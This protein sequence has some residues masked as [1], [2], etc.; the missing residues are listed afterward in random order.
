MRAESSSWFGYL[1]GKTNICSIFCGARHY[2]YFKF[3]YSTSANEMY[4][5][6]K[7]DTK[8]VIVCH[9]YLKKLFDYNNRI[10][11]SVIFNLYLS[12]SFLLRQTRIG[13]G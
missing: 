10:T 1:L 9:A 2:V 11:H 6:A 12:I 4:L 7:N 8:E 3:K 13:I 5:D